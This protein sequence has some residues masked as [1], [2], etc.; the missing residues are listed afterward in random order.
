[1]EFFIY[2]GIFGHGM[3]AG[4]RHAGLSISETDPVCITFNNVLPVSMRVSYGDVQFPLT[5][6]KHALGHV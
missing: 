4:V 3:V 2:F 1:M 6:R 5:S